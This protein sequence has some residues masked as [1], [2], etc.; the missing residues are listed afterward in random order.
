MNTRYSLI[1]FLVSLGI[2]FVGCDVSVTTDASVD[3]VTMVANE[4]DQPQADGSQ[5]SG[6]H[7]ADADSDASVA[8]Y[9]TVAHYDDAADPAQQLKD[10]LGRAQAEN[11]TVLLQVGGEWCGWCKRMTKY[12]ADTESVHDLMT[13]SFLIQKVTYN[14]ENSNEAFLS[15][16]PKIGGYPHIFVL[17]AN[18]KLLHSQDTAKLEEGRGY[19]EEAFLAF[20]SK[21]KP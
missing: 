1:V 13:E 2:L 8:S 5:P 21:W 9:Y 17:D 4:K 6:S 10:T 14:S 15:N 12:I 20:L 18:G 16:Y 3:D 19:S 11:K 7:H